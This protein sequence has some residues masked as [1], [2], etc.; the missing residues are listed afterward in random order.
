M[1]QLMKDFSQLYVTELNRG[2]KFFVAANQK[3]QTMTFCVI[4]RL[5]ILT[6][7]RFL[8][9][10][11]MDDKGKKQQPGVFCEKKCS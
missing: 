5:E 4:P 1:C 2:N 6:F 11:S 9:A 8:S 7:I 10:Y 3:I